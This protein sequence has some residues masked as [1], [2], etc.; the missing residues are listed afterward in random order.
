MF[1]YTRLNNKY[2]VL[3]N[4]ENDFDRNNYLNIISINSLKY[5]IHSIKIMHS[6]ISYAFKENCIKMQYIIDQTWS[7]NTINF[8]WIEISCLDNTTS[9]EKMAACNSQA[10]FAKSFDFSK[11]I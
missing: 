6:I 7:W 1:L 11:Y 3:M 5:Q 8:S 9:W 4:S 2:S 10:I